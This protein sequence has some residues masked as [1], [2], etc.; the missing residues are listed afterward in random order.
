MNQNELE[1]AAEERLFDAMLDVSFAGLVVSML[2]RPVGPIMDR[3]GLLRRWC[4]LA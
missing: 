1:V 4:C 2:R 3:R